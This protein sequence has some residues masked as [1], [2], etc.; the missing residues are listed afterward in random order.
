[1]NFL[2]LESSVYTGLSRR[3]VTRLWFFHLIM[4]TGPYLFPLLF[5]VV[6]FVSVFESVLKENWNEK[7]KLPFVGVQH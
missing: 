2:L 4:A 5:V 7:L 1:M 6:V 3:P